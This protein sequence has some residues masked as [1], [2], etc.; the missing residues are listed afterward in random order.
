MLLVS[1]GVVEHLGAEIADKGL[2][3]M[4]VAPVIVK[5]LLALRCEA[6]IVADKG[7]LS[8]R[9]CMTVLYQVTLKAEGFKEFLAVISAP[10]FTVDVELGAQLGV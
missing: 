6:T 9:L 7:I 2:I 4:I 3:G 10:V 1:D 5:P 8:V